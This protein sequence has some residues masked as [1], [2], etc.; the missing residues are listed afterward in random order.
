MLLG[1]VQRAN[2]PLDSAWFGSWGLDISTLDCEEVYTCPKKP[3]PKQAKSPLPR[4][5]RRSPRAKLLARLQPRKLRPRQQKNPRLKPPLN[6]LKRR[7]LRPLPGRLLAKPPRKPPRPQLE[8]RPNRRLKRPPLPKSRRPRSRGFW[9]DR[10]RYGAG[11]CGLCQACND[12]TGRLELRARRMA[13]RLHLAP[14]SVV[15][16]G[17]P[18]STARR[19]SGWGV[20]AISR[21]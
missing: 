6:L 11:F 17:L 2:H 12:L 4:P 16:K 1:F 8:P 13:S 10:P 19:S 20:R 21:S 5:R 15:M 3:N 18:L 14:S 7:L 9:V